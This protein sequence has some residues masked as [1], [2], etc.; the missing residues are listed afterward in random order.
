MPMIIGSAH[1]V[2]WSGSGCGADL[3]GDVVEQF[4]T[5]LF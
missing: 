1:G 2:E 5:L 4:R 3:G